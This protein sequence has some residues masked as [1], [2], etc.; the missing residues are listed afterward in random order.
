[1]LHS[2]TTSRSLVVPEWPRRAEDSQESGA[3]E[4]GVMLWSRPHQEDRP[5]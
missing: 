2:L 5:G 1:M 4:P 3:G